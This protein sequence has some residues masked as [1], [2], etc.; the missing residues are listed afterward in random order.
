MGAASIPCGV[1]PS[2][3]A[4][5]MKVCPGCDRPVTEQDTAVLQ[6][7]MEGGDFQAH[8]RGRRVRAGSKWI[9]ML[10]IL[11]A[12]AAP[13]DYAL[14]KTEIDQALAEFDHTG[15]G[16][17]DAASADGIH[18]ES[19]TRLMVRHVLL[20]GLAANLIL[21]GLMG[22]LWLWARRAPLPAIGCA[23]ALFLVVQV[24]AGVWDPSSI[25]KG[26]F[27]KLVALGALWKGLK[28][29]LDARDAMRRPI[30]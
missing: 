22:V 26:I 20:R 13:L 1:C 9:G 10:A 7:R 18:A 24:V 11:F 25:Y 30:A 3:I 4:W 8:D 15:Q 12:V 19:E 23:L 27:I 29:A 5:G 21:A 16:D 2:Q 6:V 17:D 14:Q 28:A